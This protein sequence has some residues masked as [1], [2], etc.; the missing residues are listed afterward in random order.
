MMK[1]FEL[2]LLNAMKQRGWDGN[3]DLGKRKWTLAGSLFYSIIII[4]TIGYGDQTPKTQWGKIAT[5]IYSLMGISLFMICLVNIGDSMA[6]MF[7]FLYWRVCC[8][9]CTTRKKVK[10]KC[11]TSIR[12]PTGSRSGP[13]HSL[14]FRD[15]LSLGGRSPRLSRRVGSIT[16]EDIISFTVSNYDNEDLEDNPWMAREYKKQQSENPEEEAKKPDPSTPEQ[17]WI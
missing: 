7:R 4:S 6:N 1:D 11:R 9:L 16:A 2:E 12:T 17:D 8:V 5:I 10:R 14:K 3:E 15:D 13:R